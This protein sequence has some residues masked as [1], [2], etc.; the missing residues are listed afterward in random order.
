MDFVELNPVID[1]EDGKTVKNCMDML[2]HIFQSLKQQEH[3]KVKVHA[4]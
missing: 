4:I 2:Q 3:K 1:E